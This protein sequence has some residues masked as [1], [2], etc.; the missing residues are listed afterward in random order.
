MDLYLGQDSLSLSLQDML[1]CD[2]KTEMDSVLAGT[3]LSHHGLGLPPLDLDEDS[4]GMGHM[5]HMWFSANSNSSNSNFNLDFVGGD[6]AAM[7]VNPNSVMPLTLTATAVSSTPTPSIFT[8]PSPSSST[9]SSPAPSPSPPPPPSPPAPSYVRTV[10][11][12]ATAATLAP[13]APAGGSAG[14]QARVV[15]SVRIAPASSTS[16]HLGAV[17]SNG[18][19]VKL[20]KQL[21]QLAG[22]GGLASPNGRMHMQQAQ[23]HTKKYAHNNNRYLDL[24]L[25]EK[26]YPKPAYSYSCLIAMAL[27]NS[28][29]GSLPVSDIY[30]FMW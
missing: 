18:G 26:T 2:I 9:A 11:N 30:S 27:K 13:R 5:T 28:K 23:L 3:D 15:P 6:G 29:S 4:L 22:G 1:D 10:S 21:Q 20:Q 24:D 7:M 19:A 25:D 14:S 16:Q 8:A 12:L 17:T